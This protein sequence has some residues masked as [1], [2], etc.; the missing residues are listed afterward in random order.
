LKSAAERNRAWHATNL[1]SSGCVKRSLPALQHVISS[2]SNPA[3]I[4]FA[5]HS[6]AVALLELGEDETALSWLEHHEVCPGLR[7]LALAWSGRGGEGTIPQSY[8][9]ELGPESAVN[10]GCL[11]VLLRNHGQ[12][13]AQDLNTVSS[14][15]QKSKEEAPFWR[16]H[17]AFFQSLACLRLGEVQL[18]AAHFED[19]PV[20]PEEHFALRALRLGLALEIGLH[21]HGEEVIP[22]A[23]AAQSLSEVFAE[24]SRTA[25]FALARRFSV[26][27][28]LA[29]AF[30]AFSPCSNRAFVA[31]SG[32]AVMKLIGR[33]SVNGKF[34]QPLH[35]GVFS[36]R[37]FG[38]EVEYRPNQRQRE[39]EREAT[40]LPVSGGRLHRFVPVAPSYLIAKY[41]RVF[42]VSS[43]PR[44]QRSALGL[45]NSHGVLPAAKGFEVERRKDLEHALNRLLESQIDTVELMRLVKALWI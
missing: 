42:E 25:Q 31:A 11:N 12:P 2:S 34:L 38:L 23:E 36:L 30:M 44:W 24:L 41:W 1:F 43:D 18:A 29:G 19:M 26:L 20:V 40:L 17:T 37:A 14:I 16:A 21:L 33:A 15:V 10:L 32:L 39:E 13:T 5:V 6:Y 35:A 27:L 7:T 8:L 9:D 45:A 4:E 3:Y 28:P 22:L